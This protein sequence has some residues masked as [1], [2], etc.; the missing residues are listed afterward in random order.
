MGKKLKRFKDSTL[1]YISYGLSDSKKKSLK[2]RIKPY[3]T[4]KNP[5]KYN[6]NDSNIVN[7]T[8]ISIDT[9]YLE[10]GILEY[11]LKISISIDESIVE[12]K[13]KRLNDIFQRKQIYK[14]RVKKCGTILMWYKDGDCYVELEISTVKFD[15]YPSF[16]VLYYRPPLKNKKPKLA[17]VE[18][19]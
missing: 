5:N 8:K 13:I 12:D 3:N 10:E 17:Y 1:V 11:E 6:F 4:T 18:F 2:F 9:I 7:D 15:K 16:I 19:L 14:I